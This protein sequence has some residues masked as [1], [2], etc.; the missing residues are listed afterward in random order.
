MRTLAFITAVVG[1]TIFSATAVSAQKGQQKFTVERVIDVPA[2]KVWAVVGEDFGAVANSHPKI[3][4]S[5]Y[6]N[7]SLKSGEGAERVCNF[8]ES[9]S[10]Y[11]HEKQLSYD[12]ENMTFKSQIFHAEGLPLNPDFSYAVYKVEAIDENSCRVV[13]DLALL[14][15]PKFMGRVAKGKFKKTISNYL[16]A[17]E[18]HAKTGENVNSENFKRIRKQYES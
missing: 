11:V 7:G 4:S 15:K 5:S 17:I 2:D 3:A 14:T 10:K 16:I 6:I 12:P 13:M 18:H 9:G 1:L 8:N